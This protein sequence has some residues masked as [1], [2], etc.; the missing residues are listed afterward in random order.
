I[1]EA[2]GY[3][4]AGVL[5]LDLDHIRSQGLFTRAMAFAQDH[6]EALT[7]S[8]QCAL[9]HVLEGQWLPL[10]KHWNY[11]HFDFVR[12]IRALGLRKARTVATGSVMHFNNYDRPWSE[13]SQ[14]PLKRVYL[15]VSHTYPEL[16]LP[17]SPTLR[18]YWTRFK[19][20]VKGKMG[21]A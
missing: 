19:R 4:N 5:L 21:W 20:T 13:E 16:A 9:H 7:Y 1:R 10:E 18:T 11:Q 12:D 15:A 14:H 17:S 8:D 3:F 2:S 6:P